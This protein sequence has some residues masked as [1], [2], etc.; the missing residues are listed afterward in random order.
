MNLALLRDLLPPAAYDF[1]LCGPPPFMKSLFRG[2]L[3]WGVPETRIHYEFFGP[4]TVL[5]ESGE[6][7]AKGTT[8]DTDWQQVTF[9]R[10]G[11]TVTWDASVESILELAEAHGLHPAFSC[12]SGICHTCMS[13]LLEGEVDYT[14]EPADM[15]DPGSVL[16]CCAQP[17]SGVVLDI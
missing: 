6:P 14:T 3:D 7:A 17:R 11:I 4:A 10:A 15:P 8:S 5:K 1:Y 9:A 12:R 13:R 2:L 16:I